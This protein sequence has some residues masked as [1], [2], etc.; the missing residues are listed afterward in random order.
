MLPYYNLFFIGEFHVFLLP[1]RNLDFHGECIL[2]IT[3]E[4]ISLWNV[5]EPH[6]KIVSWPLTGLRRYGQ[7]QTWFSIEAGRLAKLM[8]R[9][10][11]LWHGRGAAWGWGGQ[12]TNSSEIQDKT[13][14]YKNKK[15]TGKRISFN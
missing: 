13:V 9:I 1:S 12:R 7:G 8:S 6:L 2:Q 10:Q 5:F 15:N 3:A 14:Q 4:T 11:F